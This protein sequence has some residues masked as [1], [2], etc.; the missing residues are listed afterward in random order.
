MIG[1]RENSLSEMGIVS[2][3]FFSEDSG[4]RQWAEKRVALMR[5]LIGDGIYTTLAKSMMTS[6]IVLMT[7]RNGGVQPFGAFVRDG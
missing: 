3:L 5:E 2:S 4:K 7:A 6:Q 1:G